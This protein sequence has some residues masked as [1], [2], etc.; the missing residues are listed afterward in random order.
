MMSLA[1]TLLVAVP[2]AIAVLSGIFGY[3]ELRD[4]LTFDARGVRAINL[5]TQA[6]R[7]ILEEEIALRRYAVSRR[8]QDIDTYTAAEPGL[9]PILNEL[10]PLAATLQVRDGPET[11]DRLAAIH[12]KWRSD[13]V[14]PLTAGRPSKAAVRAALKSNATLVGMYRVA[15]RDFGRTLLDR[16]IDHQLSFG[17]P[18][19]RIGLL[20]LAS[21]GMSALGVYFGVRA[22]VKS[23]RERERAELRLHES[24]ML[25]Q[26][27]RSWSR[28]F[29]RAVLPPRLPA[30]LGCRLDAVYEP[31]ESDSHVGGDWYDAVQ[32]IDGRLLISIGDVA[33][34][35][36]EAAVVMGMAR[37]I[38]RGI[39]QVHPDPALMLDAADRALRLE[40]ED[41]FV[42]AWV[43]TIDLV[44][45]TLTYSSAG[46]PPALLVSP[47]A[48]MTE[49]RDVA[50]PLGLREGHQGR[51]TTIELG[52]E[53]MLVCYTDGLIEATRDV[54]AGT[55][56][57]RRAVLDIAQRPWRGP[58]ADIARRVLTNGSPDDVAILVVRVDF[59]AVEPFI[60]RTSFD[61]RDA[62]AARSA[63]EVFTH[64]LAAR[65]FATRD[66]LNAEIVFGELIGNVVRH[67]ALRSNVDIAVECSG[68]HTI[69]HVLDRGA[70]FR[71]T[72]RLPSDPYAESGRGLFIISSITQ[73][74]TVSERAGGGSHARAI[75]VGGSREPLVCSDL[76]PPASSGIAQIA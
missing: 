31:G 19:S 4:A 27:D 26:R 11:V 23:E 18:L 24:E 12:D 42:T 60:R 8:P 73:E 20:F 74:F 58:A 45:R 7:V 5:R 35:G 66:S 32:L 65:N 13:V 22:L 68:P 14:L 61:A 63:R 53:S 52:D 3:A 6:L 48:T 72:S 28:S 21:I 34:S 41:V 36:V 49:L 38:M 17:G 15:N 56:L 9:A 16:V 57:M 1:A 2:L 40:H 25:S 29:Q 10:A 62:G 44:T 70:G 76:V 64:V 59:D 43:G 55:A 67:V 50:P 30:V 46:H 51:S 37:Q 33:G 47:E 71:H 69:L 75:L 54:I 39:A